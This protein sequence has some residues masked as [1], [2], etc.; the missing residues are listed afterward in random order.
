MRRESRATPGTAS[1]RGQSGAGRPDLGVHP[2]VTRLQPRVLLTGGRRHPATLGSM[3]T[4]RLLVA[5]VVLGALGALAA[6]RA[7]RSGALP[8]VG[9]DTWPPVPTKDAPGRA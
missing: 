3:T 8:P 5:I 2:P 7:S 9:G 1:Q 6:R 4:K